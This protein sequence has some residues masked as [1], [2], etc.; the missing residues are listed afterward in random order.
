MNILDSV[1]TD[2]AAESA[3]LD[4]LVAPLDEAG[5]RTATPAVGWDIAHQIAHLTW[6]DRAAVLAATGDPDWDPVVTAAMENP[7]GFVDK[8]ASHAARASCDEILIHWRH[9]RETLAA[10]L[11]SVPAGQKISWFGPPMSATSMATA[12]FMETWAHGLD[13]A[14]ALGVRRSITDRIRQV[15]H[16]GVRT[17]DFSFATHGK[18]APVS[19][20]R[21]ELTSPSGEL[22]TFGPDTADQRVSGSAADFALLVTQRGHR[23]D[24]DLVAEGPDADRW[25]DYAQAFAGPPGPG[26][27]PE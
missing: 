7:S 5:W 25:L 18:E 10:V 17:R 4:D 13:V 12:R 23:A 14:D 1:L 3:E 11:R 19:E 9:A 15:V 26:R 6:T 24:A 22:W 27:P 20:F 16:L 21:V 2:L 8:A